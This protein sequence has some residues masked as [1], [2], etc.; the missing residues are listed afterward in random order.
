[1]QRLW[2]YAIGFVIALVISP[3]TTSPQQPQSAP[4]PPTKFIK[5]TIRT[6]PGR[7]IVV[8]RDDVVRDSDPV[9]VRRAGVTAIAE[10]H[11][12]TYGG[13]FDYVY[14]TALKG[15]AIALPDE[16]AAIAISNLPE[17]RWVEEDVMG[18]VDVGVPN[19][20]T[21]QPVCVG[22]PVAV[23]LLEYGPKRSGRRMPFLSGGIS[24]RDRLVIR[25]GQQFNQLWKEIA[26]PGPDKPPPPQVDFS[27]EMLIV[28]AMGQQPSSGYEI[29]IESACEVDNQLEVVVRSANYAKCGLQ[30]G[31]VTAPVD[32]VRVP[33]TNLPVVFRETEV[34]SG[35]K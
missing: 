10:R 34:A 4:T 13:K 23:S 29:I 27:R 26:G 18:S 33:K 31:V 30:L 15:Y 28:A 35:C 17:V 21:P 32:I 2:I 9:E 20:T 22:K 24:R 11:A 8:L 16:A 14:E 25:D 1:M 12:K 19:Q 3:H 6:I 7:Y 5:H